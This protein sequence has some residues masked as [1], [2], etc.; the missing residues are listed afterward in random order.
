MHNSPSRRIIRADIMVNRQPSGNTCVPACLDMLLE[1]HSPGRAATNL[2]SY[3]LRRGGM[4]PAD[5]VGF[6]DD[7]LGLIRLRTVRG[8]LR[9]AIDS[10]RPFIAFVTAGPAGHAVLVRG[11]EQIDGV[12]FLLVLDPAEGAYLEGIAD[13]ETRLARDQSIIRYPAIWGEPIS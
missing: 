7:N 4:L 13:F 8:D 12:G 5:A 9:A 3:C 1:Y 2:E 11:V 10:G 6:I